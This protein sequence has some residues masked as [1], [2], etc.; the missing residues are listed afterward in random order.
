MEKSINLMRPA[1]LSYCTGTKPNDICDTRTYTASQLQQ[2]APGDE[3]VSKPHT[4]TGS[5]AMATAQSI[6]SPAWNGTAAI[7]FSSRTVAQVHSDGDRESPV[8]SGRSSAALVPSAR[9]RRSSGRIRNGSGT[10]IRPARPARI[11]LV[12]ALR[13]VHA[14]STAANVAAAAVAEAVAAVSAASP[15]VD[16][17]DVVFENSDAAKEGSFE[18]SRS[19]GRNFEE[20][21][22]TSSRAQQHSVQECK[23]S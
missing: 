21:A 12:E 6:S 14:S 3:D 5:C 11:L 18:G 19:S 9:E 10:G 23:V 4:A 2:P 8:R 16:L 22:S 20:M 13:Q 17:D 1:S 7:T 15:A